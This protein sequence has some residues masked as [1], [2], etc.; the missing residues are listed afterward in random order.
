MRNR[1]QPFRWLAFVLALAFFAGGFFGQLALRTML[2]S[3]TTLSP[4]AVLGISFG[5]EALAF[6]LAGFVISFAA[7]GFGW[8]EFG[9]AALIVGAVA[10]IFLVRY[11]APSF[12]RDR[13]LASKEE[14]IVWAL[15]TAAGA[16]L[17]AM[18]GASAGVLL[19]AGGKIDGSFAFEG[20]IAR[21]HLRLNGRS[22][23]VLLMLAA[24]PSGL[25][26]GGA[27]LAQH[28]ESRRGPSVKPLDLWA[29]IVGL[30]AVALALF[31]LARFIVARAQLAKLQP[32][33]RRKRP[34]TVVMTA[35]SI[36]G[37]SV[38]V[39]ALTVVLSVMS[40]FEA[41][42]KKKILGTN[43]HAWLMKY[44]ENFREWRD[45][46]K[47]VQAMPN[48]VGATPFIMREV[49]L[50]QRDALSGA[51]LKGIDPET[52]GKVSDLPS[53]V[54][55]GDLHWLSEPDKIPSSPQP[56]KDRMGVG[57]ENEYLR[58]TFERKRDHPDERGQKGLSK[59][60]LSA[61]PGICIGKEMSQTLR[62]WV[63]DVVNVINPVGGGLGPTGPMPQSK[64]FRVACIFY[65]GMFEYDSKFAYISLSEAQKFFRTGDN[66]NG[67]ELKFRDVDAARAESQRVRAALGGF[68]YQTKDWADLNRNLF[69]ALKLEK[70]AMAIILTFIVLVA[71]FNI[72]STLIML[73]LE[74]TKEISILKSMGAR[75]ASVMKIFV[76]EGLTIGGIG[77]LI[78]LL[79]G[80][81]SCYFI[82]RFGLQL[83]PDVYYISNLPV[84]VDP[85]QF[86]MVAGIAVALSY[87]ATLYPAIK[88][89]RLAP[90]DGL[91]EE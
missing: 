71:C 57:N 37:V 16:F 52:I 59:E 87:L 21:T 24:I 23:L 36:A 10:Y 73:V 91:R 72:L 14:L 55:A 50:S 78:G 79:L 56:P 67:L 76:I 86:L 83:D 63:G 53:Q 42:L 65:T 47:K 44:N 77:T 48:V 12:S 75:D 35:I 45:V 60:A 82:E 64:A 6:L 54:K 38:G 68:P 46:L 51:E 66:I 70:L 17:L 43:S 88:A 19:G 3:R 62:S 28:V 90:V 7:R 89:S 15:L 30:V 40:G 13:F 2:S 4:D 69:S 39:W 31:A 11:K 8:R 49:M 61:M 26:A 9:A 85:G 41:D 25:L 33:Q 1:R 29:A 18:W 22:A 58:D 5:A 27:W 81:A 84:T 20:N 32:G 34:A 80:L 74:K